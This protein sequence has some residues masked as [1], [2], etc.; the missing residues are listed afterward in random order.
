[1]KKEH[2]EILNLIEDYL[3]QDGAEHLRFTQALF[4]LDINQLATEN[5][6]VDN[7]ND[8]DSWVLSRIKN[9]LKE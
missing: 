4:N 9:R 1:M 8:L 5:L 2:R 7:Y 6:L 3:S